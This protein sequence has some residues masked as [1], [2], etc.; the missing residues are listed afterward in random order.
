MIA[1][2]ER[3]D[4]QG[5]E[6][7]SSSSESPPRSALPKTFLWASAAGRAKANEKNWSMQEKLGTL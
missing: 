5:F 2:L 3:F 1:P 4:L 7:F 6:N